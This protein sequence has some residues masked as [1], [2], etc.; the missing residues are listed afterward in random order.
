MCS[1]TSALRNSKLLLFLDFD[2][3]LHPVDNCGR[4]NFCHLPL[5]EAVVREHAEIDIVISSSWRLTYSLAKLK[6]LFS[7][8]V[9]ERIIGTT[10]Q[11]DGK[12]RYV[13]IAQYLKQF[14]SLDTPW[15]ALDDNHFG[16]PSHSINL[17]HCIG[18][19]GL[20]QEVVR[21]LRVRIRE[22]VEI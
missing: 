5:F 21:I 7:P 14:Y 16:F 15:L 22:M 12:L 8:A 18:R 2:G 19:T 6:K 13:E 3:V 4:T 11:S 17:V 1:N 9:A 20:T 10:G